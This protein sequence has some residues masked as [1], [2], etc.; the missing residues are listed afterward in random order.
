LRRTKEKNALSF[1]KRLL[2]TGLVFLF[3]VL[4][5]ASFF[6]KR[7]LIE[8]YQAQKK[9]EALILETNQLMQERDKLLREIWE[10]ENNPKAIEEKARE[11]LWLMD[12]E[13]MVIVK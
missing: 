10:L 2:L 3:L 8:I 7:G 6:G 1:R 13:E 12:P 9:K 4:L 5:I 11:R